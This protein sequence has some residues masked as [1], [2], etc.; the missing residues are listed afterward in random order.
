[1]KDDGLSSS[2]LWLDI[3]DIVEYSDS[4]VSFRYYAVIHT[5]KEDIP[6]LKIR[7]MDIYRDYE[8][9]IGDHINLVA[10]IPLGVYVKRLFPHRNNLEISVNKIRN[11]TWAE[12]GEGVENTME[13]YK[14]LFNPE[15]NPP[16]IRMGVM[17]LEEH[18]LDISELLTINLQLLDRALEPLRIKTVPSMIFRDV[19]AEEVLHSVISDEFGNIEIDGDNAI[20]RLDIVEIDNQEPKEALVIPDGGLLVNF[21]TYM[22][23]MGGGLYMDGVGTYL[24]RYNDKRTLFIYPNLKMDRF[25]EV[26]SKMIVYFVPDGRLTGNE[27]TSRMNGNTLEIVSTES[28]LYKDDAENKLTDQGSGFRAANQNAFMSKPVELTEDGPNAD[29]TKLT[30]EVSLTNKDDGVNFSPMLPSMS[31]ANLYRDISKVKS[32]MVVREQFIWINADYDKVYPGMPVRVVKSLGKDVHTTD[33]IVISLE[34]FVALKGAIT[35]NVYNNKTVVTV[36]TETELSDDQLAE[37]PDPDVNYRDISPDS[38]P[39][40]DIF[41]NPSDDKDARDDLPSIPLPDYGW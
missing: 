37:I 1:M 35:S 23:E 11:R 24:Q 28:Q 26:E 12:Y 6:L 2:P 4:P 25:S 22:Q 31:T 10:E 20:D 19:T 32:R 17:H 21:P 38:F 15:A 39:L 41:S 5:P 33:G 13:R 27:R 16:G 7:E 30:H 34:A 14:V 29:R 8:G 36:A 9:S 3:R 40:M 18:T